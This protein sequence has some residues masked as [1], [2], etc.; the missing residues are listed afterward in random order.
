MKNEKLTVLDFKKEQLV[1]LNEED[2]MAVKGGLSTLPCIG[3]G[4]AFA[5]L[6]Y[7]FAREESYLQC[8]GGG[9]P[10]DFYV[11]QH[12]LSEISCYSVPPV[13]INAYQ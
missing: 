3:I 6:A 13:V 11:T 9:E 8:K 2:M 12:Q 10:G 5:S 4:L 1:N 7:D